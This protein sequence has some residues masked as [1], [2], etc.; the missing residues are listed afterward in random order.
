[1][2]YVKD[3]I[4]RTDVPTNL[5][6]LIAQRRRWLNGSFFAT[7]F[8]INNWG[9][10][11]SESDHG[12]IR[13]LCFFIQYVYYLFVIVFSWFLPANFYLALFYLVFQ[14]FQR[15]RW[16][17]IDVSDIDQI[18]RDGAVYLFNAFYGVA[19]FTQITI[20]LGNKPKHVKTTYYITSFIFGILMLCSSV[21]AVLSYATD[22]DF[23][24]EA[25]I[26]AVLVIGVFFIGS[27]L[28]CEIHHILMTFIQYMALLPSF[29]NILM[30]YSFCNLHDLSWGTKGIDSGSGDGGEGG[31][32]APGNYKDVV[33]RRKAM[34]EK[35]K[36][37]AIAADQLKRRFDAF[38]SNLL[39]MWVFSN[40]A[41]VFA[42]VYL[43]DSEIYLPAL[44]IF[45]GGINAVRLIG[46]IGYLLY[47]YRQKF[48]FNCLLRLGIL[49]RRHRR[50]EQ[51]EQQLR[52]TV[53]RQAQHQQAVQGHPR[54]Q[55]PPGT[56]THYSQ[57][58]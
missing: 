19:L 4:A 22:S 8:S 16:N 53:S 14:G 12:Y 30:V 33:A 52:E 26:A 43:V 42:C 28:H 56:A 6:D 21:I 27:L 29:V 39:L 57:M 38:R 58:R 49:N 17:F 48:V 44:F 18:Y 32:E 11:Y 24:Y 41:V 5:I 10:V 46:C 35:K 3:A 51:R 9:R 55:A 13:K 45:V 31:D 37:D 15:D 36:A 25:I 1:M 34:E 2:H 47:M 50:R 23:Q 7:L 40:L 20:G 54:Q